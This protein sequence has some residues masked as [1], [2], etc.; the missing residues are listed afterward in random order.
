MGC[1]GI[2]GIAPRKTSTIGDLFIDALYKSGAIPKLEFSLM[3]EF[4]PGSKITFG[5]YDKKFVAPGY[6]IEWHQAKKDS[7]YWEL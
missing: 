7:D 1:S 4:P 5:G 2:V 6:D 3:I